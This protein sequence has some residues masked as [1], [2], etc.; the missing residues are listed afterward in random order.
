VRSFGQFLAAAIVALALPAWLCR[1]WNTDEGLEGAGKGYD[2]ARTIAELEKEDPDW[3][4]IGNSMLYTRLSEDRLRAVSGIQASLLARGRSQ[5]AM[6]WLCVK[7]VL[8]RSKARP[9]VVTV[10][11]RD[12]DL[13]WADFRVDGGNEWAIEDLKSDP[14]PEWEMVLGRRAA[15]AGDGLADRL[16]ASLQQ[17][18]PAEKLRDVAQRQVQERAFRATRLG[19]K[20]NSSVRRAE[21]N[22]RFSLAHLRSDLGLDAAPRSSDQWAEVTKVGDET[23]DTGFYED[24]PFAFDASPEASFLPHL[25]ALAKANQIKLHFHRVKRRPASNHT[26]PDGPVIAAYM[27]DLRTYLEANG[28]LLTDESVDPLLTL[29]M[30]VDGDHVSSKEEIQRRYHELFW[31]R[32]R[33]VVAPHLGSAE[34]KD[35]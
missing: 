3:V 31:G 27:R 11:F 8:L 7:N 25:V 1:L 18:F 22:D 26:R 12:T 24:G 13:T 2:V 5:S 16:S 15:A 9:E 10:F 32:V 17:L 30:Y 34:G 28:C 19:T 23:I 4:L 20:A 14:E 35:S 29:D 33:P 21:L 6:W